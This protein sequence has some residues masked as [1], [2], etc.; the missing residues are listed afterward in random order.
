MSASFRTLQEEAIYERGHD[1]YNGT[2]STIDHWNDNTK[3]HAQS[4]QPVEEYLDG[5]LEEIDT[6]EA[7]GVCLREPTADKPGLYI[8]AGWAA[9]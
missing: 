2:I 1:S 6:R 3:A 7:V 4:G 9:S 5:L 8:F